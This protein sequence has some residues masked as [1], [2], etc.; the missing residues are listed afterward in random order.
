MAAADLPRHQSH[1]VADKHLKY[2]AQGLSIAAND[3]CAM[4]KPGVF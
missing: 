1:A 4:N 2:A 3:C